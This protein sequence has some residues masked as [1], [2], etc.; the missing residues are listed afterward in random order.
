MSAIPLADLKRHLNITS[1][2]HDAELQTDALDPAE[3]W[4]GKYLGVPLGEGWRDFTVTATGGN[5]ILPISNL[6]AVVS[7]TDPD[8][9]AVTVLA[10]DVNLSAGI[11]AVPYRKSGSW[12]VTV[13]VDTAVP[14]DVRLAVLLIAGHLW[15]TQRGTSPSALALQGAEP[16]VFPAGQGYA[17]P[18]RA[19][20]LLEPYRMPA[21]A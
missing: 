2:T 13:N 5:L 17:I 3:A 16:E 11:I 10:R 4:V 9:L 19:Q 15:E 21:V 12:T 6:T 7:V 18:N 14:A 1:S 8:G 20:A